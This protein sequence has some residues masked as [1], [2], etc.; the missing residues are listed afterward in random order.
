L[1]A[2]LERAGQVVSRSRLRKA[3]DAGH[4]KAAGK[5]LEPA[6]LVDAPMRVEVQVPTI[7]VLHAMPEALPLHVV[8]EDDELL[9]VD[10]PAPMV[11]HP[12]VGH[13]RG[14]LVGAVLHHL[15][16]DADALPVLPGN[17]ASRPGIVHRLDRDTS[18]V[19]VIAKTAATQTRL[20][21]QFEAHT[22]ERSYVAVVDGVPAWTQRRVDTTHA[23]DPMDRRRFAPGGGGRRAL[24]D[25]EVIESL[26]EAAVLRATLHT[27]RTHQIRMHAR[28]VDHPVYGDRLYGRPPKSPQQRALWHALSRHALHAEVLAFDH[29]SGE[30]MRFTSP[31]PA[32]L[33]DLIAALR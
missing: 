1:V 28:Y 5:V 4:V 20:A 24:T 29:P 21:K 2:A 9:V 10:K 6:R 32:E 16:V 13:E 19:I 8:H 11:V 27:G 33:T 31:L 18:G 12:S 3:F 23:R 30:R 26:Q 22:I 14:T 15:G 7:A 25:F 17:D